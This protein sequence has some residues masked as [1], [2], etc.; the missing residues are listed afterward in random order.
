MGGL[1]GMLIAAM[2][3]HP[4]RALVLN[5]VGPELDPAGLERIQQY[6][7]ETPVLASWEEAAAAA[8]RN[9]EAAFPGWGDDAWV[10]FAKN[11]FHESDTGIVPSYDPA[12]SAPLR[13]DTATA[14]PPDL[15]PIFEAGRDLP[16]LLLRGELSDILAA[17]VAQRMKERHP[18]LTLQQVGNTG[19]APMLD[20]PD[21]W[22]A[23]DQ[24]L[25]SLP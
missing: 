25:R 10:R 18:R 19:H 14:V 21:A 7:G 2:P 17:D 24:F 1:M 5:D 8:R 15:W 6:V 20:E 23:L 12:I 4:M 16:T 22:Q 3:E 9:N 13:A 11:L